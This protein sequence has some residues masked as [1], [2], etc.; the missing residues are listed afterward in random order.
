MLFQGTN[1]RSTVTAL[2]GVVVALALSNEAYAQAAPAKQP[3]TCGSN[4]SDYIVTGETSDWW[5]TTNKNRS[6][7]EIYFKEDKSVNFKVSGA[8]TRA[9][10]WQQTGADGIK[11]FY[12][13]VM[14]DED[15]TRNYVILAFTRPKCE[16]TAAKPF[17]VVES[18]IVMNEF[19]SKTGQAIAWAAEI[20]TAVRTK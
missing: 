20:G 17:R 4:V 2:L 7:Y 3:R 19:D 15:P 6:N 12:V 11:V 1:R 18:E 13:G 8:T 16:A 14:Y 9:F 5:V 10:R